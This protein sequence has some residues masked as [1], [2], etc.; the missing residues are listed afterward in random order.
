MFPE[1]DTGRLRCTALAVPRSGRLVQCVVQTDTPMRRVVQF[2]TN[3]E[4]AVEYCAD[5]A[6]G[7]LIGLVNEVGVDVEGGRDRTSPAGG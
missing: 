5:V 3:Q 2:C 7:V 4:S 6:G 1:G